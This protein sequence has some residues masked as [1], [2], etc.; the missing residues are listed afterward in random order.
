MKRFCLL[1]PCALLVFPLTLLP[2]I[3]FN[4]IDL[5]PWSVARLFWLGFPSVF[6][7]FAGMIY[8]IFRYKR[9]GGLFFAALLFAAAVYAADRI[10]LP[11]CE[12]L[13]SVLPLIAAAVF[14]LPGESW[15]RFLSRPRRKKILSP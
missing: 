10:Q 5:L 8:G 9:G 12:D 11:F 1:I 4:N 3:A 6:A 13:K 7:F 14:A 2:F 15:G